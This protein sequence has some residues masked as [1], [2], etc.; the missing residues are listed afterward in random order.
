MWGPGSPGPCLNVA[1]R[2][3]GRGS[4][5]SA[6]VIQPDDMSCRK[7]VVKAEEFGSL[8]FAAATKIVSPRELFLRPFASPEA[9]SCSGSAVCS[10]VSPSHPCRVPCQVEVP[11]P[12]PGPGEVVVKVAAT[13]I[14]A[15]DII[16]MAGGC[17]FVLFLLRFAVEVV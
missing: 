11:I 9:E 10:A 3:A 5:A 12:E 14:E 17:A 2:P 6:A 4:L 8:D 13:G 15:S 1:S 16:Q 7:I